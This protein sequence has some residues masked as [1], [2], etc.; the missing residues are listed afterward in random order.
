MRIFTM[1]TRMSL[2]AMAHASLAQASM[3]KNPLP[4]TQN[5]EAAYQIIAP[6][7]E[8]VVGHYRVV[9]KRETATFQ[10][11]DPG[12]LQQAEIEFSYPTMFGKYHYLYRDEVIYGPMGEVSFTIHEQE[13]GKQRTRI[14]RPLGASG[15]MIIE[16]T[17]DGDSETPSMQSFP[18]N[19][20]DLTLFSL[21]FPKPCS[22]ERVGQVIHSRMLNANTGQIAQMDSEYVSF[23][24]AQPPTFSAPVANICLIVTKSDRR[25][26]NKRSWVTQDGYLLFEDSP[27]YRLKLSPFESALPPQHQGARL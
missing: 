18:A 9:V 6:L 10:Q 4:E 16:S 7:G 22:A 8:S 19:L 17:G 13:N 27:A 5:Y 21:R 25:E 20:Y 26:M 15:G 23:G 3:V 11:T 24:K 2:V 1:L 14:G 12:Y